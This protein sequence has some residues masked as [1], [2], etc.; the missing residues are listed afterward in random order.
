MFY[1]YD[2]VFNIQYVPCC[3]IKASS[4]T[5]PVNLLFFISLVIIILN[6]QVTM[7]QQTR[8]SITRSQKAFFLGKLQGTI[9]SEKILELKTY[10]VVF[11]SP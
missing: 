4:F 11:Q 6:L 1:L 7:K 8:L 2:C 3:S 10:R 9:Q 5:H